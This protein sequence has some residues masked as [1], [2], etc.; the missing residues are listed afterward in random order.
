[1]YLGNVGF[2]SDNTGEPAAPGAGSPGTQN[3]KLSD[4]SAPK[5]HGIDTAAHGDIYLPP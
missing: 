4:A 1:M 5:M 3:T 2:G